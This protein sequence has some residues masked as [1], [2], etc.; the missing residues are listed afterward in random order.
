[1]RKILIRIV[2]A[3]IALPVVYLAEKA[4]HEYFN[5]EIAT[6]VLTQEDVEEMIATRVSGA[7]MSVEIDAIVTERRN[8]NWKLPMPYGI[9][10]KD[11]YTNVKV[12]C[13]AEAFELTKFHHR[14]GVADY[15]V[16]RNWYAWRGAEPRKW[17]DGSMV[18]V[19]DLP[20]AKKAWETAKRAG[21]ID[22]YRCTNHE[23]RNALAMFTRG[24]FDMSISM[25]GHYMTTTLPM[26]CWDPALWDR[27]DVGARNV[28]ARATYLCAK[29]RR[30]SCNKK[31]LTN[32]WHERS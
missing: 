31:N 22:P 8:N 7:L 15:C 28:V 32:W 21:W 23:K 20:Y 16:R 1:M 26:P 12:A 19:I 29:H 4:M 13:E 6:E 18:H 5:P 30:H 14:K 3:A 17:T 10:E 24:Y 11:R 25:T 27:M 2:L 9:G